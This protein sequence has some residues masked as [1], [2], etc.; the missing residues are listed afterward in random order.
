MMIVVLLIGLLVSLIVVFVRT[1]NDKTCEVV[2]TTKGA[3]TGER[4][5]SELGRPF[6]AFYGIPYAQPP[7]GQ[8][9]FQVSLNGSG[10]LS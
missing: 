1:D 9:R 5:Y 10:S 3:V 6:F 8:L 7:L 4:A 2:V